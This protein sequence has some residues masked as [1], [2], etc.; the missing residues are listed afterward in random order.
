MK[1]QLTI[2]IIF[3]LLLFACGK[4]PVTTPVDPS[5]L[6]INPVANVTGANGDTASFKFIPLLNNV[7][8]NGGTVTW[9]NDNTAIG[10]AASG[11]GDIA[12]FRLVNTGNTL[13]V[14][15]IVATPMLNGVKGTP[16]T[17][18][19]QVTSAGN[20]FTMLNCL[21]LST[22]VS[23]YHWNTDAGTFVKG[24]VSNK[25][26][27]PSDTMPL[28]YGFM[29]KNDRAGSIV[30]TL[31]PGYPYFFPTGGY[32]YFN[33]K[34]G[35]TASIVFKISKTDPSVYPI[36]LK[37]NFIDPQLADDRAFGTN[38]AS[39]GAKNDSLLVDVGGKIVVQNVFSVLDKTKP[40]TIYS[41]TTNGQ[42]VDYYAVP[43]VL[44]RFL[45]GVPAGSS[46]SITLTLSDGVIHRYFND[47]GLY[48]NSN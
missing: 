29:H 5:K 32:A 34:S 16:L 14:A 20:T 33:Y 35:D 30:S 15:N 2:F 11:S 19:V 7:L 25:W 40:L 27:N 21:P 31:G 24:T 46:F 13:A 26:P 44:S 28:Y 23:P 48:V 1:N 42:Y 10:L 12:P 38:T 17:V 43:F 36:S 47:R 9:T 45:T 8:T 18:T 3:S 22:K 37:I 39:Y 4:D 6:T 41:F